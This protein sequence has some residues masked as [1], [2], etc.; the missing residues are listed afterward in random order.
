MITKRPHQSLLAYNTFGID[1]KAALLV[2]YTSVEDLKQL[3]A[4]KATLPHPLLSVGGGS[5]LLFIEDFAGTV[6]HSAIKGM[7]VV[8]ESEDY[9]KVRAGAGEVWDD[10][11]AFCVERGWYGAENLSYIPGEVG[12]SAVQNIGAYGAE[13]K[14]IVDCVETVEVE[15]GRD[16][17]FSN[18]DCRF[19][20]RQS[21]FKNELKGKYVVTYVT[22][23][24]SKAAVFNLEYGNIRTELQR[25]PEVNLCNIR[26][27]IIAIREA[28]LPDPK[29]EGNGGSF[30]MN[31][32]I[33]RLQYEE[34]KRTYGDM[35]CYELD[36][37]RVKVPAAW[38]I[39]RC[40]WKGRR[41]G[42]AGVHD[43]QALVL[44]N[45][46]GATGDE[47]VRLSQAIQSSVKETFGITIYPEVN[48]IG[49][50]ER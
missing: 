27:A 1:V 50:G 37:D 10:F 15:T 38:M 25:Y 41:M 31:P 9:V 42:H 17:V 44:V 49:G 19:A 5:N 8:D 34:L 32:V 7:E 33:P 24:L 35:P 16:K 30:F 36:K 21:V 6:L 39:D 45:K 48:F 3:L 29:V 13:A 12:A 23:R 46:G 20:Y 14:D 28:K 40:G 22:Y 47:I 43:K 11:V 2:E 26:Q 18:A 4:E